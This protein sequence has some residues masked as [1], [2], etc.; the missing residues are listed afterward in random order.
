MYLQ[1]NTLIMHSLAMAI[2]LAQ[3]A[4]TS[5]SLAVTNATAAAWAN[6]RVGM[7]RTVVATRL[8]HTVVATRL[9]HHPPLVGGMATSE[10]VTA[11]VCRQ[12]LKAHQVCIMTKSLH[13]MRVVHITNPAGVF[14][15]GDWTCTGC[16]NVNWARRGTCNMCNTPKPGTMDMT[17]DGAKGG[18]KEYDEAEIEE[19]RRRR[20]E[21]D[22]KEM[23]D[24]Y[25]RLKKQFRR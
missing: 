4:T 6:R 22:D 1:Q 21:N 10:A 24:E 19:A 5:I 11:A 14:A 9:H 7:H 18:F 23:Y 20:Q 12:H 2:G 15:P 25:G 8:R 16:G 3:G 13:G 17:R